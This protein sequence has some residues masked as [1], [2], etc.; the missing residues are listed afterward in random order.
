MM[1]SSGSRQA[2]IEHL[3]EA[4]GMYRLFILPAIG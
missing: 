1:I 2:S 3:E 4:L